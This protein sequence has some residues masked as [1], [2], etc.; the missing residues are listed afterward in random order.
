VTVP[1]DQI[2][3]GAWQTPVHRNYTLECCDCGLRHVLDFRIKGRSVQFRARRTAKP[4]LA[5]APK[6]S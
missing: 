3:D 5:I 4:S 6:T 1:L 2:H